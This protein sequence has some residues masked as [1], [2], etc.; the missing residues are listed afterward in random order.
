MLLLSR[1]DLG[2]GALLKR[3]AGQNPN[4]RH[5]QREQNRKWCLDGASDYFSCVAS[6]TWIWALARWS[7]PKSRQLAPSEG[8]GAQ[9]GP[10]RFVGCPNV[11]FRALG[12][13]SGRSSKVRI[14]GS[15]KQSLYSASEHLSTSPRAYGS[16][17]WL[18]SDSR[19]HQEDHN[20]KWDL[21]DASDC[22]VVMLR[23]L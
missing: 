9:T 2:F 20:Y 16:G 3:G 15:Y 6:R 8:L 11:W 14:A 13:G 18:G 12:C 23:A 4:C 22:F 5:R 1:L 19:H 21:C 17:F 7:M 10:P